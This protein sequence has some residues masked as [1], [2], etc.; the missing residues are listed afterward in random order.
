MTEADDNRETWGVPDDAEYTEL[1]LDLD[2]GGSCSYHCYTIED[3]R[4]LIAFQQSLGG[5]FVPFPIFQV[6]IDGKWVTVENEDDDDPPPPT[7]R[8]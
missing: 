7:N 1:V 3:E 5:F 8:L 2:D 4:M 6:R